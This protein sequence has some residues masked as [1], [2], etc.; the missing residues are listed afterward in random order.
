[1]LRL[2]ILH[3]TNFTPRRAQSAQFFILNPRK[4]FG[5]SGA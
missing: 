5:F 2:T 3:C 1:V 4:I